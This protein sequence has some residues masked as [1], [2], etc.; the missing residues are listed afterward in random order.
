VPKYS[1]PDA[2]LPAIH[3]AKSLLFRPF[4]F[5]YWCRLAL[6]GLLTGEL[7]SSGC[8][9]NANIPSEI[10]NDKHQQQF[11]GMDGTW[12]RLAPHFWLIVGIATAAFV[13]MIV[14]MYVSSVCRFML[15]EAVVDGHV[16]LRAGWK[17]WKGTATGYF[18]FLIAYSAS[19]WGA[20][21]LFI[22]LPV[23]I[24]YLMGFTAHMREHVVVA[25]L[26]IT[27]L[28]GLGLL[29][30]CVGMIFFVM[31]KD[32]AVPIMALENV[33]VGAAIRRMGQI[34]DR[35]KSSFAGY[36]G[37]KLVLTLGAGLA[38]GIATVIVMLLVMIPIMVVAIIGILIG[39]SAGLSWTP[40]MIALAV[41]LGVN[42]MFGLMIIILFG[43]TPLAAFFPSY[44]LLYFAGRYQPLH[45]RLF[46]PPAA[47]PE[48]VP[49]PGPDLPPE[50]EFG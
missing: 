41:A 45:D 12:Q 18:L 44:G 35:E 47:P 30:L 50:P 27:T 26:G 43:H 34:I 22:G 28:V 14:M 49:E 15:F 5:G 20:L 25:A 6:L 46:P 36:I 13:L 48:P 31:V 37:M 39:A 33:S 29:I 23:L 24:A 19:I 16:R 1:A 40:T 21:A 9:F 3:R 8:S 7:S 38:Y 11:L 42:A 10:F 17:K 2:F 4:R 32:F